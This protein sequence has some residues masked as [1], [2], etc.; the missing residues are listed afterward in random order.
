MR[1]I[2]P[3][4]H[5]KTVIESSM[6]DVNRD[7]LLYNPHQHLQKNT[8]VLS[9]LF[10]N[11]VTGLPTGQE[12]KSPLKQSYQRMHRNQNKAITAAVNLNLTYRFISSRLF[13]LPRESREKAGGIIHLIFFPFN[14][15]TLR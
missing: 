14:V 12:N 15:P 3:L 10:I 1:V 4:S 13:M 5:S 11:E 6:D 7:N 2:Q 8:G 9:T